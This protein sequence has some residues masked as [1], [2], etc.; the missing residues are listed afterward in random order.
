MYTGRD[1]LGILK[2]PGPKVIIRASLD[3]AGIAPS[4]GK[5]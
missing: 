1:H 4:H 5:S 3:K 2:F